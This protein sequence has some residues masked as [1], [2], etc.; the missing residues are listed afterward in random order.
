MSVAI[1]DAQGD[2]GAVVVS[3]VNRDVTGAEAAGRGARVLLLQNEVP[4]AANI[5]VTQDRTRWDTVILNAAPARPMS[6]DLLARLD[7]LVVNRVEAADMAGA[8]LS[9]DRAAQAL[10]AK[11]P[12]AVI[13]TLGAQGCVLAEEGG[14]T[15]LPAPRIDPISTHGAGDAFCGALAA[16]LARG[17]TLADAVGRAQDYAARIVASA[18]DD[19]HTVSL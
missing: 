10:R 11:G 2:Y 5:A 1:V 19:R 3:G 16:C 12:R 6:P 17:S 4:E 9:P 15:A 18:P 14:T 13:V 7:L 8:D